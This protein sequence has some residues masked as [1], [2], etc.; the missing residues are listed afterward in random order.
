MTSHRAIRE[1]IMRRVRAREWRAGD[2][3]PG[4]IELA[5]QFGVARATMNKVLTA[6]SDEG[7]LERRRNAGTRVAARPVRQAR[8]DIPLVRREVETTGAAY[9]YALLA[10]AIIPDG[11]TQAWLHLSCL[12]SA[13]GKP[14]MFE[15]RRINLTI[16]PTAREADFSAVNPNEWLVD[17][18]PFTDAEFAFSAASASPEEARLL[19]E[20]P[21]AALFLS[22][23]TTW[24]DDQMITFARM[25]YRP[26][27]SVRTRI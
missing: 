1:E 20:K 26:G 25:A 19:H 24:L 10:R 4:E 11:A 18:M 6:L 17:A 7:I 12:H 13:N 8:L 23:R 15:T 22:E 5:S 21:G 16:V 14:F 9:G 27:H 3:I 2:A